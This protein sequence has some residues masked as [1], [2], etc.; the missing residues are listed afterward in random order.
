[1]DDNIIIED[2]TTQGIIEDLALPDEGERLELQKMKHEFNSIFNNFF[3]A[4]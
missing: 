4:E 3:S 1:M 2:D